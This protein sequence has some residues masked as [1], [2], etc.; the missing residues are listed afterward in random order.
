MKKK[1]KPKEVFDGEPSN[2]YCPKC[3]C[4]LAR[5]N[6]IKVKEGYVCKECY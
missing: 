2:V 4:W 3:E 1:E 6:A 5:V